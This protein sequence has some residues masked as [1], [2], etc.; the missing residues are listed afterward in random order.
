VLRASGTPL[1]RGR[2]RR[3]YHLPPDANCLLSVADHCLHS[4]NRVN[5]IVIDKQPQPQWLDLDAAVDHCAA[6][7]S[8]WPYANNAG[9][10]EPDV[11]RRVPRLA[12]RVGANRRMRDADRQGGCLLSRVFRGCARNPRVALDRS[13]EWSSRRGVGLPCDR[14]GEDLIYVGDP[15]SPLLD[16]LRNRAHGQLDDL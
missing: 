11:I 10:E 5:L 15:A 8:I 16:P 13:I 1:R 12:A 3:E 2:R 7:A 14:L 6:G 9:A 4:R